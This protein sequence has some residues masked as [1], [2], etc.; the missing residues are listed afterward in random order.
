MVFVA[1][2]SWQPAAAFA[3]A[4]AMFR[5][6]TVKFVYLSRQPPLGS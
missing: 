3:A 5:I 4:L 1:A 2:L 6:V